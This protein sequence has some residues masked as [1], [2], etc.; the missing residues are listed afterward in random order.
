[1][2][3]V[4]RV[5]AFLC[6]ALVFMSLITLSVFAENDEKIDCYDE[7]KEML[8]ALPDDVASLLPEKL[9]SEN[10]NDIANGAKEL[11]DFNYIMKS[12][13]SFI[14]LELGSVLKLF[15]TLMGVLI[16]A[17]TMNAVKNSFSSSALNSAFSVCT[18]CAVF[19]VAA[20][21]QYAIVK[22]VSEF[23]TR[24]CVFANTMIPLM[25]ALYAMGGNVGS[26]VVNHSSLIIFMNIVE[27]FCARS[28]LP[29]A[30][31]CMAFAATNALSPEINLG[32]IAGVFKKLYTNTLTFI[33]T[34][35]GTVMAAQNLLASKADTLAAKTAKFAVGNMIPVVGS[36][37][38]G[39][40]GTVSTSVE[41]IRSSVGVVGIIGVVLMVL[42]TVITLLLTKL[43]LSLASGA[44]EILGC[45]REGKIIGELA[46]INGFL[47]A[48]ACICSVT[49][50]FLLTIFAKCS[51]AVGGGI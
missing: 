42:P 32:G 39:T 9:Y 40:L 29:M 31:V 22:T 19:L 10:I 45:G 49:F 25:G 14:G 6:T 37:I 44:A 27:N 38:A 33:M 34:I 24:I 15:A 48:A 18:S 43:M 36:A 30:G 17:A 1:M 2:V 12:I 11:V 20:A 51:S 3:V 50:I 47:L 21:S 41:Y 35:F 7:Y 23:F 4:K 26:A 8:D 13:F 16:L 28:A 46:G 5:M